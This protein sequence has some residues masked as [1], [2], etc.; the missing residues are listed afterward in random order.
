MEKVEHFGGGDFFVRLKPVGQECDSW[1]WTDIHGVHRDEPGGPLYLLESR[2]FGSETWE[3][4][5][6]FTPH[7]IKRLRAMLYD[8]SA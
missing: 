8:A 4:I 3:V 1:S 7:E 6:E 2:S 5:G